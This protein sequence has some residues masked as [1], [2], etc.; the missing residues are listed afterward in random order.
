VDVEIQVIEDT[1]LGA[2]RVGADDDHPPR[3]KP[4]RSGGPAR[5]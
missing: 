1:K 4:V 3:G 2:T 5:S